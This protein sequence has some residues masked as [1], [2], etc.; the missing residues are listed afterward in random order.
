MG[1]ISRKLWLGSG[2]Q[3]RIAG[4]AR[5]SVRT[6][7]SRGSVRTVYTVASPIPSRHCSWPARCEVNF[8]RRGV[9][10]EGAQRTRRHRGS[11][12]M[13]LHSSKSRLSFRALGQL[14]KMQSPRGSNLQKHHLKYAGAFRA[15]GGDFV[16]GRR[17]IPAFWAL[18]A[19][20]QDPGG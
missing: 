9:V 18:K 19:H 15:F 16:A 6:V 8:G 11:G 12:N 20:T 3:V 2:P 13:F 10:P 7:Y 14:L 1:R 17:R 4:K 5:G